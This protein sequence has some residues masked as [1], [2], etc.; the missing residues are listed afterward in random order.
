MPWL[1]LALLLPRASACLDSSLDVAT[2]TIDLSHAK[3]LD[4]SL[5]DLSQK[6]H[7]S[8]V[9]MKEILKPASLA[10]Y[11]FFPQAGTS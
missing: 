2:S 10:E 4:S 3:L 11:L 7:M 9:S 5:A 8:K 6:S 1:T